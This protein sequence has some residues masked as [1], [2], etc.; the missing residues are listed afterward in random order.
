MQASSFLTACLLTAVTNTLVFQVAEAAPRP[1]SEDAAPPKAQTEVVRLPVHVC[2]DFRSGQAAR[3]A[4]STRDGFFGVV[5]PKHQN[6]Q[7]RCEIMLLPVAKRSHLRCADAAAP[8]CVVW[9][10]GLFVVL[11]A[12]GDWEE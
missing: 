4:S 11:P 8:S 7:R 2:S 1:L 6:Y 10:H 9:H 5:D 12:V 3:G